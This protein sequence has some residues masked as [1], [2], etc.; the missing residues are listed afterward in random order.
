[1]STIRKPT[2]FSQEIN[3]KQYKIRIAEGLSPKDQ[4]LLKYFGEGGAKFVC[5][6]MQ[7]N[8]PYVYQRISRLKKKYAIAQSFTVT[9]MQLM[10]QYPRVRRSFIVVAKQPWE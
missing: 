2:Q 9:I 6:K 8:E 10:K 5:A 4:E 1:M 3:P 7:M